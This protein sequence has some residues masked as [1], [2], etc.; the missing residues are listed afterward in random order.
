MHSSLG[1]AYRKIIVRFAFLWIAILMFISIVALFAVWTMNKEYTKSQQLAS[2]YASLSQAI[3]TSQLHFK[4]QIQEWK[5]VLLR[6]KNDENRQLY[7]AAFKEDGISVTDL[8]N[9][10]LHI[11]LSLSLD[12]LCPEINSLIERHAHLTSRYT[13]AL[14][15]GS[16]NTLSSVSKV[17]YRV[18]GLDRYLQNE[19]TRLTQEI[20]ILE[21]ENLDN[22]KIALTTRY[23]L[24]RS[25]IIIMVS[26][27]I[28]V[29]GISIYGVMRKLSK[30]A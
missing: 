6:G 23:Q 10:S 14:K 13:S 18:K 15:D 7:F 3:T 1:I 11:C 12:N 4:S 5:N 30:L 17:D 24:I 22:I 8:L 20:V 21:S 25:F 16:L 28:L 26:I 27:L 2:D 19:L 9:H 29:G